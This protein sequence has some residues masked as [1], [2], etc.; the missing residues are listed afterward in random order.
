MG[1]IFASMVIVDWM[2]AVEVG[3]GWRAVSI[4]VP[5]SV[6]VVSCVQTARYEVSRI[7]A[8]TRWASRLQ[9]VRVLA[10]AVEIW[11]LWKRCPQA[12]ILILEDQ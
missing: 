6:G 1:A 4:A 2:G 5:S 9:R 8:T 7:L 10:S 3:A 11:V 12:H